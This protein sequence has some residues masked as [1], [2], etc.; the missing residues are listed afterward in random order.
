MYVKTVM[1]ILYIWRVVNA[2]IILLYHIK[3]HIYNE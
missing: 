2:I 3:Q 1:L